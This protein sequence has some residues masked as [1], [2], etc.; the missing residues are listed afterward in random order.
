[1]EEKTG[2]LLR[3][4]EAIEGKLAL[5]GFPPEKREFSPH[6]TLG[7]THRRAS[8]GEIRKLGELIRSTEG[9]EVGKVVANSVSLMRSDLKPTGAVYT[10]LAEVKL[11]G[12]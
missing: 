4:Q 10:R 1:V 5:L 2:T 7:R 9:G 12:E 11:R 8:G 6:L 3:L